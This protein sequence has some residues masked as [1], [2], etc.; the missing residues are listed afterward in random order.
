MLKIII[1]KMLFTKLSKIVI[2]ILLINLFTF[3]F[4]LNLRKQ[5]DDR[6]FNYEKELE[7]LFRS[8]NTNPFLNNLN[9][10]SKNKI[11]FEFNK[12]HVK[13]E[14]LDF[15]GLLYGNQSKLEDFSRNFD[16]NKAIIDTNHISNEKDFNFSSSYSSYSL[17]MNNYTDQLLKL[18]KDFAM[19]IPN[20]ENELKNNFNKNEIKKDDKINITKIKEVNNKT[21]I[22]NNTDKNVQNTTN[23]KYDFVYY[24][25]ASGSKLNSLMR[26]DGVFGCRHCSNALEEQKNS[27]NVKVPDEDIWVKLHPVKFVSKISSESKA[28]LEIENIEE[29]IKFNLLFYE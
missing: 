10:D 14:H 5:Y 11:N 1:D 7:H 25:K 21:V 27:L 15:S 4:S 16:I 22:S 24:P 26:P 9:K 28:A 19:N 17:N 2:L 6:I 20:E 18:D 3:S 23:V 29:L 12:H 8:N 13:E